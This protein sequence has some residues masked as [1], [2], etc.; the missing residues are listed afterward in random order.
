MT[1]IAVGSAPGGFQTAPTL[2][3][4]SPLPES[5]SAVEE[6]RPLTSLRF[7]AALMIVYQHLREQ[8]PGSGLENVP[9]SM[10]QGVSFFFV[11][12]GFILTHVYRGH[13]DLT[14]GRFLRLRLARLY[15]THLVAMLLLA[16]VLP[17]HLMPF[18]DT[19]PVGTGV[20]L[21]AK[22]LLLDSLV[23]LAAVQWSWNGVSWSISTE[24]FFYLAFPW[25]LRGLEV[26]WW[27]KLA[28]SGLTVFLAYRIGASVG[29][30]DI[31]MVGPTDAVFQFG[32]SHPLARI[33]EFVL[34]MSAYLGWTRWVA[35]AQ[36][37]LVGWTVVEGG[38]LVVF[39]LWFFVDCPRLEALLP[40]AMQLW[41]IT[42]GS[43]WLFAL[44]ITAFASGRGLFGRFLALRPLV[45]L[46]E[47]SFAI[48]MFHQIVLRAA[49]NS[50]GPDFS[51]PAALCAIL[52]VAALSHHLVEIPARRLILS[53]TRRRPQAKPGAA[54]A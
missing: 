34:G 54:L 41:L 16:I 22:L 9:G 5:R 25:L 1:D 35:N 21:V 47:I 44:M 31:H 20:S 26:D 27:K 48:Y 39:A 30:G 11:L 14:V 51:I 46:G 40:Q 36:L 49:S 50:F 15:P 24:M 8:L 28:F 18:G 10:V 17:W 42:S 19:S 2:P 53:V 33:F 4:D 38:V 7:F 29:Y 32:Y 45:W 37:S 3:A 13:G 12:S 6:L 23:P 43:C 52:L